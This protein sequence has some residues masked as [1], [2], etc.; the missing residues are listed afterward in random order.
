MTVSKKRPLNIGLSK[1]LSNANVANVAAGDQLRTIP[2]DAIQPGSFQ[3]RRDFDTQHLQELAE[4]IRMQ[5]IVQ[6]IILRQ[7]KPQHYEIIAGERRWRAAQ[8]AGL[9][10]VPAVIK[11]V[12]DQ[13]ALAIGLIENIQRQDLNAL[14]EANALARLIEEFSLTHDQVAKAVGKS[15]VMVSNLLRLLHLDEQVKTLLERNDLEMG[16]ARSLLPLSLIQQRAAAKQ[17]VEQ[18]LSVREAEQLVK[19]MLTDVDKKNVLTK[20]I[21][22]NLAKLQQELSDHLGTKVDFFHRQS[23]AGKMVIEYTNLDVLSGI[24]DKIHLKKKGQ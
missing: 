2:L 8:M 17:I 23:G 16:H 12:S 10:N 19:K 1:M 22:P 20:K 9:A 11:E 24:L 18:Q 3:P 6:P 21:N 7:I 15:R 13:A 5:G 14:E 4:S